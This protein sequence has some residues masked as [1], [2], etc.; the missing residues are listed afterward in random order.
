M[1]T[2]LH[3]SGG[4]CAATMV[5]AIC[6][7]AD[8]QTAK[9]SRFA[10]A[11]NRMVDE[12]VVG[13]GVSDPRVIAAMRKT[14]RH[15]FVR[16]RQRR[17]AY[18]DMALPIGAGQTISPPYVVAF[19]TERLETQPADR[20][21]EIGT[22]SGYQA[23][24]L[25]P[26]VADVYTIEIVDSLGQKSAKV[27]RRLG[28]KNVHAKVGDGYQGWPEHAP[29]DK[30]I[31]TCS[32]EDIPTPLVEQ[33]VEGGRM[34]IPLG[35]RFQQSLY[36]FRK[37]DG[38]LQ[39]EALEATFFVP[40]TGKAEEE[41][42]QQINEAV[43]Q[44]RHASFEETLDE[45]L[46]PRGW[47]Y[48]RQAQVTDEY[49]ATDGQM[50]V[51]L[52]N[53]D[54]GRPSHIMQAFGVDGRTVTAMQLQF[55]MRGMDLKQGRGSAE[56]AG[57]IL[58]F[59]GTQRSPVGSRRFGPWHGTFEWENRK[60]RV[61]VPRGARLAIIGIGLFGGTGTLVVDDMRLIADKKRDVTDE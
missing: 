45:S 32:P 10:R 57:A 52:T 59:Y 14:P 56:N 40:M 3:N 5:L 24:V 6:L 26:L 17:N 15:E 34:V 22:G 8:G 19:M 43:P 51:A 28:Y 54:P 12:A 31:V 35:E 50:A 39:R 23:A 9:D 41:R 11:R 2:Y 25:S 20:V 47:F 49:G 13:G 16:S 44:L 21:L 4:F 60:M 42:Q 46:L 36:L 37:V 27:L 29:F 7:A 61:A 38:K 55:E 48:V 18:F 1:A 53:S 58:E 33:L 30:I